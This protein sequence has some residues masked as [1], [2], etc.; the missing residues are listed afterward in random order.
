MIRCGSANVLSGG[1][2]TSG[3]FGSSSLIDHTLISAGL[4]RRFAWKGRPWLKAT[5][6][7]PRSPAIGRPFSGL[8][9]SPSNFVYFRSAPHAQC[10]PSVAPLAEARHAEMLCRVVDFVGGIWRCRPGY[11]PTHRQ[12]DPGLSSSF[13]IPFPGIGLH[14]SR[15]PCTRSWRAMACG[16]PVE[17]FYQNFFECELAHIRLRRASISWNQRLRE[18]TPCR[19]VIRAVGAKSQKLDSSTRR[20]C[21]ISR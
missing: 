6:T 4:D 13:L 11:R 2:F 8:S 15:H 7:L 1:G 19:Q 12:R 9:P 14:R 5:V 17:F 10:I 18:M 20:P 21:L 16:K 3:P